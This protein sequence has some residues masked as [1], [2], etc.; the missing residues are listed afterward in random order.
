MISLTDTDNET[1][2]IMPEAITAVVRDRDKK[3]K[4]AHTVVYLGSESFCFR[5]LDTPEEIADLLE[6]Y[7]ETE[8][9]IEA[10]YEPDGDQ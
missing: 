5:V 3:T 1:I 6:A 10:S 7:Y 2:L 4:Q 9:T 8:E